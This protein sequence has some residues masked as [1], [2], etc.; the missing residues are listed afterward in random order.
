MNEQNALP[1]AVS[2]V[3]QVLAV[4]RLTNQQIFRNRRTMLFALVGLV[5]P[6]LGLLFAALRGIPDL[7]INATGW[8]FYS[9][10]AVFWYM[11]PML[12]LVTMFYGTHLINAEVEER[13]LTYLLIRP[14]PRPL[15][16]LGKYLTYVIA[17]TLLL[18][19]S[20]LLG[21]VILETSDGLTGF[22]R[23]FP[24]VMWDMCVLFLGAL[25]YGALF[26][27]FG[28][29]LRRPIMVG[30]FFSVVWEVLV[31]YIPGRFAKFT[32]LHYLLSLLRHST[33]QR[34]VQQLLQS[35]SSRLASVVI[36]LLI[37]A[38]FLGLAMFVFSRREYVLEQ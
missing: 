10:L 4:M 3:S 17:A 28:T 19:P 36:L 29:A 7:H 11:Q 5:P 6:A 1:A 27:L 33:A 23:H 31:T 13:T 38:V 26:L 20:L 30:L 22:A 35:M 24:S 25:A 18:V 2:P 32:I 34:V 16:V 14:V 37:S 8:E 12:L 15:L 21:W 9:I